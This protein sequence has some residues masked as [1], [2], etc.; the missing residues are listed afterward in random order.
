MNEI[1]KEYGEALFML[2]VE[3]GAERE[4]KTAVDIIRLAFCENPELMEVLR[5]PNIPFAE[6]VSLIDKAF[7]SIKIENVINFLKLL[8]E[9]GRITVLD[10]AL[11]TFDS[12]LNAKKRTFIAKVTSAVELGDEQKLRLTEKLKNKYHGEIISEYTVDNRLIGGLIVEI[13]GEILDGSLS[14]R[15][16]GVKEVMGK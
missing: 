4:Y 1:G 8:C 16:K 12:L 7:E 13:D 9:K 3:S 10:E 15:L 5:S 11:N 2:A 6:R 14:T